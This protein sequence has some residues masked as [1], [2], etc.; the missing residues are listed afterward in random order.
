MPAWQLAKG[1]QIG[2]GD[3]RVRKSTPNS[4]LQ[5]NLEEISGINQC[6]C[7]AAVT[8]HVG[9]IGPDRSQDDEVGD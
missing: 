1:L 4:F 2:A 7:Q 8:R 3:L 6:R 5:I 9:Y